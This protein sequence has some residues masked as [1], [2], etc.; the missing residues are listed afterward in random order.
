MPTRRLLLDSIA[1]VLLT[2]ALATMG[3]LAAVPLLGLVA[4]LAGTDRVVFASPHEPLWYRLS[5]A[6]AFALPAPAAWITGLVERVVGRTVPSGASVALGL[7]LPASGVLL[8]MAT[9]LRDLALVAREAGSLG[10]EPL[11]GAGALDLGPRGIT[12][13]AA[14][15]V[16]T[17]ALAGWAAA[18][19]ARRV[20][21]G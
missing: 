14:F 18:R 13:G 1:A 9:R 11:V 16:A 17:W 20:D 7:I 4:D 6:L 3:W 10:L 21:R 19:R 5:V 15:S 8:A 12:W 2:A